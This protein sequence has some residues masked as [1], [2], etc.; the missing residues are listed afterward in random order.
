MIVSASLLLLVVF[1]W[2]SFRYAWWARPVSY[3][4]PRILMY[5]MISE[6]RVG[7]RFNGLRVSPGMFEK[8]LQWLSQEGWTFVTMHELA[9]NANDLP[10]KTVAITFDDGFEDNY[11]NAL[12]LLKKYNAKATLYLELD[13]HDNDWSSKKKSHHDSGELA[14]ETKLSDEQVFEL[15]NSKVFEIGGHTQTHA[16]LS[17]LNKNEKIAE[18]CEAKVMLENR[19][20]IKVGSFAYPFGIY[21]DDDILLA[22]QAGYDSAVIAK[23]GVETDFCENKMV[24]S[25]VKISGKDGFFAFKLRM[26]TGQRGLKK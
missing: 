6:P 18:I 15:I 1:A 24:A 12:P 17:S 25:R 13:R 19:F 10:E 8:Q 14:A 9:S 16:N 3:K 26:K 2:F 4:H 23:G 22:E 21:A 11:T 20:D 7:A 5:H